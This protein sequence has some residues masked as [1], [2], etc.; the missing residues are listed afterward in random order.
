M[1]CFILRVPPSGGPSFQE[2]IQMLITQILCSG[3]APSSPIKNDQLDIPIVQVNPYYITGLI[4]ADGSFFVAL[5][6]N[7]KAKYCIFFRPTLTLTLWNNIIYLPK[8][9][10][11]IR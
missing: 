11:I 5:K 8:N 10:N 1:L 6:K 9:K 4:Q 3:A 7:P 2:I